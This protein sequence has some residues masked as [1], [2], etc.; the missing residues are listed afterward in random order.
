MKKNEP[1]LRSLALS[2]MLILICMLFVSCASVNFTTY[3]ND[4]G[5]INEYIHLTLSE[6]ELSAH[7]Y[8]PDLTR[9]KIQTSSNSVALKLINDYEQKLLQSYEKNE[10][11]LEQYSHF[12]G[13]VLKVE[14]EWQNNT[15]IIGL[16]F[17]DTQT[18]RKYY[19]L[20]NNLPDTTNSTKPIKK[21]K[22]FYTKTYYYGTV[23]Y[24]DYNLFNEVYR[25][26][27]L[28]FSNMPNEKATLYYSYVMDGKRYHSNADSVSIDSN[29]KYIHTWEVQ[30]DDLEKQIYFYTI[31][32]NRGAWLIT[33]LA[34]GLG[35]CL[36]L[37]LIGILKSR[38]CKKKNLEP[39]IEAEN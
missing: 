34:I 32:A 4:D 15:Y 25:E 38:Q 16:Q 5:T 13:A 35:I 2:C 9:T 20:L 23:G 37:C 6:E 22:K 12:S 36:I 18:Y 31:K 8:S 29:G 17:K 10:I 30:P 1:I 11:S 19:Q 7:G 24:N 28:M 21:E 3:Y 26:Y 39:E 33:C 14:Q 27:S